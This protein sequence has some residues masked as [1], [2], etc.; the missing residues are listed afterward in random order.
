DREVAER[1]KAARGL[2]PGHR[3]R[4]RVFDPVGHG[5]APYRASRPVLKELLALPG[6]RG[7]LEQA[8]RAPAEIGEIDLALFGLLRE[9]LGELE[10]VVEDR[11]A[12]SRVLAHLVQDR[13]FRA[14]GDDRVRD[15]YDPDE[16]P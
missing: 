4:G 8:P 6:L 1:T 7:R 15:P 11:L 10:R 16:R 3:R 9:P 13:A 2:G 5:R 14:R 12:G